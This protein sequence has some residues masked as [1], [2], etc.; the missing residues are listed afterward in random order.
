MGSTSYKIIKRRLTEAGFN[1]TDM[2]NVIDL[3]K[4]I[5][6]GT[7]ST[8]KRVFEA[9]KADIT[10]AIP[11]HHALFY[12]EN[13][14]DCRLTCFRGVRSSRE[15][16]E[17]CIKEALKEN[18]SE[19]ANGLT[20]TDIKRIMTATSESARIIFSS[21]WDSSQPK[22]HVSYDKLLKYAIGNC[23]V[24]FIASRQKKRK[25]KPKKDQIRRV[26]DHE[27]DAFVINSY[28]EE[29]DITYTQARAEVWKPENM[30]FVAECSQYYDE[31][32]Q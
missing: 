15:E 16:I 12:C 4:A 27:L 22:S 2:I 28:A 24:R 8:A 30:A 32:Q 7:T 23:D 18:G 13:I 1:H 20:V 3:K 19:P 10:H 25:P 5:G 26:K 31:V 14:L 9:A 6:S 11:V 17:D 29:H 21:C